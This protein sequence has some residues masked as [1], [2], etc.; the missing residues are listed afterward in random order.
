VRIELVTH[1]AKGVTEKDTLL[2]KKSSNWQP[3]GAELPGTSAITR[4][5][6]R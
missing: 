5:E 6:G 3:G 4:S 2:V 1:S